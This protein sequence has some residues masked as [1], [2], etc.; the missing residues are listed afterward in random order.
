MSIPPFRSRRPTVRSHYLF[1]IAVAQVTRKFCVCTCVVRYDPR[2]FCHPLAQ[3]R[4]ISSWVRW[5][6]AWRMH[7]YEH[8]TGDFLVQTNSCERHCCERTPYQLTVDIINGHLGGTSR[9]YLHTRCA[10]PWGY[11]CYIAQLVS[12]FNRS[13]I[14]FQ[15]IET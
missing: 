15:D 4:V 9:M 2:G 6:W 13:R 5:Q 14:R 10:V 1:F 12:P 3:K 8:E 7:W 11:S